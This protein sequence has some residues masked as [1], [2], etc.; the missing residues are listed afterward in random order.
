LTGARS[1]LL[2]KL[3]PYLAPLSILLGAHPIPVRAGELKLP[4]WAPDEANG[5][6][7]GLRRADFS[8]SVDTEPAAVKSIIPPN[9]NLVL[10]VVADAVNRVEDFDAARRALIESMED[11][12][13]RELVA[14][15]RAQ[16]GLRVIR[17]PSANREATA[18][19][20]LEIPVSGIPGLLDSVEQVT[21]IAN[22]MIA[23]SK[24]RVAILYITDGSIYEYRGDYTSPVINP[25]DSG[26][27]S[28]RFRDRLI[29]ERISRLTDSALASAAP[30]FFLHLSERN[31][32]LNVVYQNGLLQLA[33]ATGGE[34]LFARS[35][36]DV[37]ALVE[38]L[39][40]LIRNHYLLT[41]EP[42]G[43]PNGLR[44][45]QVTA[46][47]ARPAISKGQVRISGQGRV[48]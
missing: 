35:L 26:D 13:K 14:V 28:R 46:P 18:K 11:F 45:L 24:V 4:V 22:E 9:G 5:F 30:Q 2:K 41:I 21:A 32:P 10:L 44:R 36:G 1:F 8:V 40:R 15:L 47:A 29:Q 37:P 33:K 23:K 12:N 39:V 7:T 19:A 17:D 25:S 20:L 27:L 16:D 38:R 31:D 48:E 34:A 42:A 43:S 6:N 3:I